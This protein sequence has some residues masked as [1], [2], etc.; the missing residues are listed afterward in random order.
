MHRLK[1]LAP[2]AGLMLLGLPLSASA[3]SIDTFDTSQ[4]VLIAPGPPNPQTVDDASAAAEAVGGSREI[5]LTRTGGFGLAGLDASLSGA[6]LLSLS[7]GAA[8]VAD[9]LLVY[10]G[11]ADGSVDPSG[12]GGVD[13]TDGGA[14][15]ILQVVARSDLDAVIRVQIHSGSATDYLFA[16]FNLTGAGTGAGAFQTLQIPLAALVAEG[17]GADVANVG[18]VVVAISGQPSVDLQID[19]IGTIVPEPTSLILMGLGTAGLA[20]AGRRRS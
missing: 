20:I 12:L 9:A 1:L 11:S 2:V 3:L 17:L 5:V 18:A 8:V 15:S 14:S 4:N 16:E 13:L 10:D 19:S 7:T 6:G